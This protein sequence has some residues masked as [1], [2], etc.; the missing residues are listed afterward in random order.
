[1]PF[2]FRVAPMNVP[3]KYL[4]H[5]WKN[6]YLD[7]A[8]LQTVDGKPLQILSVGTL[9]RNEGA[10]FRDATIVLD[11]EK[12]TGN[13][14][15]HS[16]TSDWKRHR[17]AENPHYDKVILHV[18]FEHD[19]ELADAP[20]VLELSKRLND[21]LH[22][23]LAQCV[24]DEAALTNRPA[25]HCASLL[26][27]IDDG[28]KLAWVQR[29]AEARFARK[30]ERLK[31]ISEDADEQ[32]YRALARALGYA[33]NAEPMEKLAAL[34]PFDRLKRFAS[35]G[36]AARRQKLE[37]IFFSL[38]GLIPESL[39]EPYANA[40]RAE[41]RATDFAALPKLQASEWVFF[42]LRPANFPTLRL[43]A[44]AEILSKNLERGFLKSALDIVESSL[45]ATRKRALL[46]SLFLADA[47]D[48]WQT[49]YRFGA[50]AKTPLK[51]LVGKTRAAEIVLNAL[52]PALYGFFQRRG[53]ETKSR[54]IFSLFAAYPKGLTSELSVGAMRELLGDGYQIK[55]ALLEQGAIELRKSYCEAFRCLECEIGKAI[56]KR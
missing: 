19:V 42:R 14:E 37:A 51:S 49:H 18:V 6:L 55:S 28:L 44:L 47:S 48:Y 2:L 34:V 21:D 26:E 22:R 5:V 54:A 13:V 3:E 11:G 9:N 41:F 25:L 1:M 45:L 53:D 7:L 17:H 38:S 23:V 33:E 12:R 16:R 31:E 15:I 4:R 39:D 32:I 27:R 20:P 35:L 8:A 46:E 36:F 10:D 56:F 29:L 43:A 24:R 52:L 30:A 50:T 40:L